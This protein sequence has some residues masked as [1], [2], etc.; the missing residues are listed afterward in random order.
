MTCIP[1]ATE[2]L[3]L[4]Y[5]NAERGTIMPDRH[6]NIKR[7]ILRHGLS[8]LTEYA[9]S[10]QTMVIRMHGIN[11]Y[12]PAIVDED[13]INQDIEENTH[14]GCDICMICPTCTN[15]HDCII[16]NREVPLDIA[17]HHYRKGC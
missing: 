16:E 13:E 1:M 7:A 2:G 9:K 12:M 17:Y 5:Q 15:C 4:K 3:L 14:C 8:A 6:I 11:V 10:K